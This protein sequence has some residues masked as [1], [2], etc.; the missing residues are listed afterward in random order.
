MLF[1][2]AATA[3]AQNLGFWVLGA[4]GFLQLVSLGMQV[5][6]Y[7]QAEKREIGPQPFLVKGEIQF[8]TRAD[9]EAHVIQDVKEHENIFSKLGG[10]ERGIRG[11]MKVDAEKIHEKV[12]TVAIDVGS[13]KATLQLQNQ[14]MAQMMSKLDNIGKTRGRHE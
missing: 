14:F 10:I 12:N 5:L 9:F 1:S 3:A 2:D 4:V 8:A 6:R 11:E 13:V 7:Q